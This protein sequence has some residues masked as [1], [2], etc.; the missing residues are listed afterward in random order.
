MKRNT[1]LI[2]L[3]S[4]L[5]LSGSIWAAGSKQPVSSTGTFT[6]HGTVV[7]S[8]NSQLVLSSTVKGKAEQETFVVNPNTK[9]TGD[10][11]AGN[12]AVVHYK[13]E[14]GQKV[15]VSIS[16]HKMMAAKNK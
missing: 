9:S 12:S 16:A 3:A 7:S 1:L 10:L 11:A 15:A 2:A 5:L 4:V 6:M 8:T 13:N 14:N